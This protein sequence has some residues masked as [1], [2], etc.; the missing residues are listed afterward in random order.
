MLISRNKRLNL[1]LILGV[2]L[3]SL[4]AAFFILQNPVF[5]R[6]AAGETVGDNS[7]ANAA[8]SAVFTVIKIIC[9]IGGIFLILGGI[10]KYAIAHAN[11]QGPDEM[12]AFQWIVAGIILALLGFVLID[13]IGLQGLITGVQTSTQ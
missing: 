2:G 3:V 4:A 6:V 11:Q 12:K 13:A 9:D 5:F 10:I 8:V 7:A 1:F